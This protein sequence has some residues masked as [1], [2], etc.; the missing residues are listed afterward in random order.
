MAFSS[1]EGATEAEV[2]LGLGTHIGI[3]LVIAAAVVLGQGI[4]TGCE[5]KVAAGSEWWIG[6]NEKSKNNAQ[7]KS[8]GT[9][10]RLPC[11]AALLG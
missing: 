4:A 9:N 11:T 1:R 10:I 3:G 5:S 8:A 6:L 7:Q 2:A